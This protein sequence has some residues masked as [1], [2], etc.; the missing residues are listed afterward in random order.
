MNFAHYNL[1]LMTLFRE[2]NSN[3]NTDNNVY[4]QD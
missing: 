4:Y 3:S 2:G 1:I